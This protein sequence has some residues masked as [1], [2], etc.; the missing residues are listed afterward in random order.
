MNIRQ[1]LDA[2]AKHVLGQ[3]EARAGELKGATNFAR[4]LGYK[5]ITWKTLQKL[6][7]DIVRLGYREKE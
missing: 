2:K 7:Y 4:L 5:R 1:V 3:D 6:G